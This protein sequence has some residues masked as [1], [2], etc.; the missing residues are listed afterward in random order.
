MNRA[1]RTRS[2][3]FL[4]ALLAFFLLAGTTVQARNSLPEFATLVKEN[5]PAVV[6][7]TTSR[8]LDRQM[9]PER[10]RSPET[11]ELFDELMKR[12]FD[13]GGGGEGGAPFGGPDTDARGSG[14]ILSADGYV[15]TNHHVVDGSD[16]ITVKLNDR[17]E[18]KARLIGSDKRSDVALLK[19]EASGL[20]TLKIGDSS[21]LEVGEWVLAIGSPFGFES[22]ATSG[23]VSATGRSLP[24]DSYV[25][26]IQT[27]VAINPGN[28][29]GPLFNLDGEVIGINSQIYSRSGGFMGVSFAIPVNMAMDVI[30]QLK[31]KGKVS[32]GWIGV[33]IQEVDQEL[34]RSFGMT[35][36]SGALVAQVMKDGPSGKVL[37]TGDVI[38]T[39]NNKPVRSAATL[40]SMVGTTHAG[41]EVPLTILRNKARQNVLMT[42]GELPG[43]DE[44]AS[45]EGGNSSTSPTAPEQAGKAGRRLGVEV[46]ALDDIAR[47]GLNIGSGG[48]LVERVVGD[49]ARKSGLN[50]GDVITMVDGRQID[51]P[52]T[53]DSVLVELETGETIAVLVHRDSAAR[54]LAMK[55]E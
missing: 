50:A 7:V 10:F 53:L 42:I 54:F 40:P 28:S 23:I 36:P 32:R 27:D 4:Y 6:N 14:F 12:F 5:S 26:F 29:G 48:V 1:Y 33:Y 49:P 37:Q 52:E 44:L 47:K 11:D 13:F 38:L 9:L 20:P 45:R 16:D 31:D 15:V 25:P 51:S 35:T 24:N 43:E 55:I 8:K 41:Q 21:Q 17:R 22:S 39:F 3:S 30:G 18:F 34:A 46:A 2:L 19:I